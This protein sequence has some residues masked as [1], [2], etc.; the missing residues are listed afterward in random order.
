MLVTSERKKIVK[1]FM[2]RERAIAAKR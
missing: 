2:K 1:R